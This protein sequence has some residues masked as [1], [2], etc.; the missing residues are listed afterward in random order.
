MTL[1]N[2]APTVPTNVRLD[3][4]VLTY[5]VGSLPSHGRSNR[6]KQ[7]ISKVFLHNSKEACCPIHVYSD[8][9]LSLHVLSTVHPGPRLE[10]L[11]LRTH[12]TRVIWRTGPHRFPGPVPLHALNL[13]FPFPHSDTTFPPSI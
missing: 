6:G 10:Y 5:T 1:D 3:S 11:L 9:Y 8:G 13:T 4:P 12:L 7:R 2:E